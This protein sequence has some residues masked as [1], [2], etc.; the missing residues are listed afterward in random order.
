MLTHLIDLST[1]SLS[2]LSG[3]VE[4]L[5]SETTIS[6]ISRSKPPGKDQHDR[7]HLGYWHR[8]LK[9]LT[10]TVNKKVLN[11]TKHNA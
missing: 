10:V 4:T 5:W 6:P 1:E 11:T 8:R 7:C 3:G 2:L 9:N